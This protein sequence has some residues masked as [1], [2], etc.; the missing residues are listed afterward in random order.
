L[1]GLRYAQILPELRSKLVDMFKRR[2]KTN[3]KRATP[4]ERQHW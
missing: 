1:T 3:L 4:E 2:M